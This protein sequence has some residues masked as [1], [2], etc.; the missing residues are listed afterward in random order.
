MSFHIPPPRLHW[1]KSSVKKD[2]VPDAPLRRNF[3]N[4]YLKPFREIIRWLPEVMPRW[5]KSRIAGGGDKMCTSWA[6]NAMQLLLGM[7]LL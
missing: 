4:V 1:K 3:T 6:R 7:G 2:N 5:G